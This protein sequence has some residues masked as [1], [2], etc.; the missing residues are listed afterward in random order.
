MINRRGIDTGMSKDSAVVPAII[1]NSLICLQLSD[2]LKDRGINVQPILYPAVE[3]SAARLRF[4]LCCTHTDAQ[5][6][7]TADTVREE[8]TRL[9]REQ[10]NDAVA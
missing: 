7:K 1:G 2:R 9:Q 4:F 3:E 5:L 8:L 10:E 6:E